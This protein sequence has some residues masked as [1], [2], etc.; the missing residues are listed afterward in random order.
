MSLDFTKVGQQLRMPPAKPP[1]KLGPPAKR[2]AKNQRFKAMTQSSPTPRGPISGSSP[3][4]SAA[5]DR[6]PEYKLEQ[7]E[8]PTKYTTRPDGTAVEEKQ[9][10]VGGRWAFPSDRAATKK[11][12]PHGP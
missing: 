3:T 5:H 4:R 9:E 10:R 1:A 7:G 12:P 8:R 2:P 6:G 11:R